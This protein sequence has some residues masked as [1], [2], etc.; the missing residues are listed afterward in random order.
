MDHA[1]PTSLEER[2][3]ALDGVRGLALFGVLLVNDLTIFRTSIFSQF[4]PEGAPPGFGPLD[5]PLSTL[6]T[7]FVDFKAFGVFSL[8]FGVGL[9]AQ[10]ERAQLAGRSFLPLALRRL[11]FLL[12]L[13]LVHLFLIWNGDIL[14]L[15]AL[16]G[17]IAA[18][19]VRL[20]TPWLLLSAALTFALHL[21]PLP[22]PPPF[23]GM[24]ELRAHVMSAT[25]VYADG[26]FRDVL[27][28]RVSEVRAIVPLLMWA[29]PRTLSLMLAG[30]CAWRLRL[31]TRDVKGARAIAIT[32]ALL[33]VGLGLTLA[34]RAHRLTGVSSGIAQDA[35]SVLLALGYVG[36]LLLLHATKTGARIIALAAPVGRTALT[37]YLTQSVVLGFLFYGYGL[38]MFGRTTITTATLLAIILYLAQI[39]LARA[40]LS[41]FR[42]GPVEWA[43]RSFTYGKRM[44]LRV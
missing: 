33:T 25:H 19:L 34:T 42:F 41:R 12:V 40:W 30:A 10:Q 39:M 32:I 27:A 28:F 31:F 3:A 7:I 43:W 17:V 11:S 9:G 44:R 5:A 20:P 8:L 4:L 6:V 26:G 16:M 22:L 37:S 35:C 36:T 29:A 21:Y 18:L 24:P 23:P 14:T 1:A 38:G 13:G 15:Y 2:S